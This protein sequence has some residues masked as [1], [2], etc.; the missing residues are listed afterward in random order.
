MSAL[1]TNTG[2]IEYFTDD[3]VPKDEFYKAAFSSTCVVGAWP[4]YHWLQPDG[5]IKSYSDNYMIAN[6]DAQ[7]T[8]NRCLEVVDDPSKI[9]IDVL[10]LGDAKDFEV[11]DHHEEDAKRKDK[12]S[13]KSLGNF[14]RARDISYQY[15]NY[16]SIFHTI[17]ANPEVNFRYIV[18]QEGAYSGLDQIKFD[19][20]LTWPLQVKGRE[21]AQD[22][23]NNPQNYGLDAYLEVN[24]YAL[25]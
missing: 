19:P 14:L 6:T 22:I 2:D 9:T 4:N 18:R 7:S 23:I 17:Q 5:S 20:E 25:N 16:N 1:N 13:W 21:V 15:G 12:Q 3:N 10:I 8:I 11:Y 24:G